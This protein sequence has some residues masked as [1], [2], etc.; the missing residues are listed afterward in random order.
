M[1]YDARFGPNPD[2]SATR[3][4]ALASSW[5]EESLRAIQGQLAAAGWE[6]EIGPALLR[7][8]RDGALRDRGEIDRILRRFDLTLANA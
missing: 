4:A 3:I 5:N 6:T 7:A 2:M 1:E 8:V